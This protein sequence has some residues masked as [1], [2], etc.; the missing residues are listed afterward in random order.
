MF[1]SGE[2]GTYSMFS[3]DRSFNLCGMHPITRNRV[4][5]WLHPCWLFVTQV[6]TQINPPVISYH[7]SILYNMVQFSYCPP[8]PME[9]K[10]KRER[11]TNVYSFKMSFLKYNIY[12]NWD[13]AVIP[14]G[15][16]DKMSRLIASLAGRNL[17]LG[18]S[19]A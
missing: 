1:L 6:P 16:D 4:G 13:L 8:S 19:T 14:L 2:C 11:L 10:R 9:L 5:T 12:P 17:T 3:D 7:Q 15:H 18:S